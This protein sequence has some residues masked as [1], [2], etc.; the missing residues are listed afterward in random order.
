MLFK[1]IVSLLLKALLF[2]HCCMAME[3]TRDG[4]STDSYSYSYSHSSHDSETSEGAEEFNS[5]PDISIIYGTYG[6][7]GKIRKT[8][9]DAYFPG[10]DQSPLIDNTTFFFGVYDG[11]NGR[12]AADYASTIL[13][14][15]IIQTDLFNSNDKTYAL[16]VGFQETDTSYNNEYKRNNAGTT[17]ITALFD[18]K[19]L[20]IANVGDSQAIG[21]FDG[22]HAK[23]LSYLHSPKK[24]DEKKR[25]V[26]ANGTVRIFDKKFI[27][28]VGK[29]DDLD[30]DNEYKILKKEKNLEVKRH[31]Y[32]KSYSVTGEKRTTKKFQPVGR[33]INEPYSLAVSRAIGDQKFKPWCI[34]EPFIKNYSLKN[35]GFLILACDGLWDVMSH[36]AAVN[37]V[38]R[39]LAV[40]KLTIETV[41]K[42]AAQRIAKK[43]VKKAIEIWDHD[44]V[45]VTIVF[46]K[47]NN[48]L[49]E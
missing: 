29:N 31:R 9:E 38:L 26:Q 34:A 18:K 32:L 23:Q 47:I 15:K 16:E 14:Q 30:D 49:A 43:L 40:K 48:Q 42:K 46:F 11:H 41:T 13:H 5:D 27:T 19:M 6:E 45:T 4:H 39:R 12:S 17:A 44:N 36:Q 33:I 25:I 2:T 37:F 35:S 21:C 3:A 28:T 22:E 10:P 24:S 20:W 1:K 7:K 8:M